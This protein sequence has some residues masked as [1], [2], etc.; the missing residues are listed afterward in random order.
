MKATLEFILPEENQEFELATKASKLASVIRDL[1]YYI[2]NLRKHGH[3]LEN[4]DETLDQIHTE[5]WS[6]VD[7]YSVQ[8]LIYGSD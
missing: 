8:D 7:Q 4:A 6:I 3:N 2:R 1:D 5:F